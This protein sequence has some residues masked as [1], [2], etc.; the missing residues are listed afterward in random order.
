MSIGLE[1]DYKS[2][3]EYTYD[4]SN[5]MTDRWDYIPNIG[6]G[7]IGRT[8]A[9]F[10]GGHRRYLSNMSNPS[11]VHP[12]FQYKRDE[13]D[14]LYQLNNPNMDSMPTPAKPLGSRIYENVPQRRLSQTYHE[15]SDYGSSSLPPV[16]DR[17]MSLPFDQQC[18]T[19]LRSS[20]KKNGSGSRP[21]T[22]PATTKSPP[23]PTPPDSLTSDDSSYLSARE[24]SISSHSRVRF[25]PEALNDNKECGS[26]AIDTATGLHP[27]RRLSKSRHS[28]GADTSQ[29]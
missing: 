19:K 7:S 17:P 2:Y 13:L 8:T 10:A 28:S 26:I 23:N 6:A 1:R 11:N 25:S 29:S 24:G 27:F 3:P 12:T 22:A 5:Y 4:R 20:L 9:P 15:Y 21:S 16:I 14:A 18:G